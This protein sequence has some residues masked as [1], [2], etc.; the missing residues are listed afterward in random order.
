MIT[1]FQCVVFGHHG[2]INLHNYTK[3]YAL[4]MTAFSNLVQK[5]VQYCFINLV[6]NAMVLKEGM[7][8]KSTNKIYYNKKLYVIIQQ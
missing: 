3:K 2:Q 7:N 1:M 6:G 5:N 8:L 4:K